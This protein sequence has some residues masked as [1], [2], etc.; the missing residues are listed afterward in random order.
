M[1]ELIQRLP[2]EIEKEIRQ[3]AI[4]DSIRL[5]LLLNRYP[6]D[7]MDV[8]FKGFTKEQLDKVYRYG[9]VSKVLQ[10]DNGGYTWGSVN[11]AIKE[12]FKNDNLSYTLFTYAAWPTG[13]FN[14][15]WET[16]NNKQRPSRPEY[17]RRITKF[18][19]FVLSFS[20]NNKI[21]NENFARFCEKLVY[22]VLVGSLIMRKNIVF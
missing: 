21:L 2:D 18:C 8:F 13:Q 17:I 9:C 4:T 16:Q 12:L 6:L 15:Y 3:F 14:A 10:W 1:N 22:D 20:Q 7:T 5:Q 11:P 19:T